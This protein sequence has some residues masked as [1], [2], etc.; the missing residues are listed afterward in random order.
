MTHRK[1]TDKWFRIVKCNPDAFR[2][3]RNY[4]IT[5]HPHLR[6]L[7]GTEDEAWFDAVESIDLHGNKKPLIELLQSDRV[8]PKIA[9]NMLAELLKRYQLKPRVGRTKT[10]EYV[11][12]PQH[13]KMQA[14]RA[15]YKKLRS[16]KM[17]PKDA[18]KC[19]AEKGGVIEG[20]LAKYL[21][22]RITHYRRAEKRIKALQPVNVGLKIA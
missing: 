18:L 19:A 7:I 21:N 15:C 14:A 16:K 10:A 4:L 9:R 2:R 5:D 22:G 20:E 6:S 12:T 3:F 1:N 13:V 8:P 17:K 11:L